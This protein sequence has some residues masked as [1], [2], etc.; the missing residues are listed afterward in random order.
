MHENNTDEIVVS[1][2]EPSA[3]RMGQGRPGRSLR[4]NTLPQQ[5]LRRTGE[6]STIQR[7]NAGRTPQC[8]VMRWGRSPVRQAKR[9]YRRLLGAQSLC[10]TRPAAGKRGAPA[11]RRNPK[12]DNSTQQRPV[13]ALLRR[14]PQGRFEHPVVQTGNSSKAPSQRGLRSKDEWC[15][16]LPRSQNSG[17][18]YH[19]FC[20]W[21]C[22][23]QDRVETEPRLK[24][25]QNH[26]LTGGS[27]G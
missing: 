7:P 11:A 26:K 5:G 4:F 10:L 1:A 16:K 13:A 18:F 20:L 12:D 14:T 9:G 24:R 25:K 2:R 27:H 15:R 6:P 22:C 19:S 21:L 8:P 17:D 23:R 3:L